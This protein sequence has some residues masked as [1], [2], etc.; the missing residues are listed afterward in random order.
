[1]HRFFFTS[2][3]LPFALCCTAGVFTSGCVSKHLQPEPM[4]LNNASTVTYTKPAQNGKPA[5]TVAVPGLVADFEMKRGAAAV[6]TGSTE[7]AMKAFFLSGANLSDYLANKWFTGQYNHDITS[8]Y[9]HDTA[10]TM[11][12]TATA[13]LGIAEGSLKSISILGASS[14][15]INNQWKNYEAAFLL[16]T[17][18][19]KVL[20]KLQDARKDLK[21]T[22]LAG[23]DA[24]TT[25]EEVV[26]LLLEYHETASRQHVKV[27]IETSVELAQYAIGDSTSLAFNRD[28]SGKSAELYAALNANANGL[29]SL[30][31]AIT[32]VALSRE[33]STSPLYTRIVSVP[34]NKA[35]AAK[36]AAALADAT[37]KEPTLK[38]LAALSALPEVEKAVTSLQ[39]KAHDAA[40]AAQNAAAPTALA[41]TKLQMSQA[42]AALDSAIAQPTKPGK[43]TGLRLKVVPV[44]GR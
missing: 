25:Y 22:T 39:E 24:T 11:L 20:A 17:A 30:K 6:A 14:V 16:S 5:E 18:L 35:L 9:Q 44:G 8:R 26:G 42:D 38:A 10:N 2:L 40:T 32:I 7:T 36:L 19:P 12:G 41:I 27:F 21:A 15:A 33:T 43:S 37:F 1:M 34:L 31:D 23:I 4:P 13:V 3:A 28:F 29:Y